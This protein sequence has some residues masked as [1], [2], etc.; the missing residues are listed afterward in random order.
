MTVPFD[1]YSYSRYK[2]LPFP[3][4]AWYSTAYIPAIASRRT[5]LSSEEQLDI[6]GYDIKE[7]RILADKFFKTKDSE[8]QRKFLKENG[9]DYIFVAKDELEKD[10]NWKE[11]GLEEWFVNGSVKIYKV[12]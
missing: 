10:L 11:I 1:R 8:W 7:R 3:I 9:I 12:L 4:Y 5:Y 6:T 2:S